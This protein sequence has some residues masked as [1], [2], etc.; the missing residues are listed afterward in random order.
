MMMQDMGTG[1]RGEKR[2]ETEDLG[3]DGQAGKHPRVE[4]E[5][6][7]QSLLHQDAGLRGVDML[8]VLFLQ[9]A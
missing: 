7:F 9:H 2:H 6:P 5:S 8:K 4:H 3:N 1:K